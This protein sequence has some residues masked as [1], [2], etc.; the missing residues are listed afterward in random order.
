MKMIID[1]E[2]LA[3]M[4][5]IASR[6][7]SRLPRF[8]GFVIDAKKG[9]VRIRSHNGEMSIDTET[10][11]V[12]VTRPGSV[13]APREL[14]A[15][16]SRETSST[17]VME[18]G[19]ES[20]G[21]VGDRSTFKLRLVGTPDDLPPSIVPK[22]GG[23]PIKVVPADLSRAMAAALHAA[24][25][26]SK[27]SMDGVCIDVDNRRLLCVAT[28][29]ASL[30]AAV[31]CNGSPKLT[32]PVLVPQNACAAI[33]DFDGDEARIEANKESVRFIGEIEGVSV[34]IGSVLID[35]AFV[36]WRDLLAEDRPNRFSV[37]REAMERALSLATVIDNC[38]YQNRVVVTVTGKSVKFSGGAVERG[39]AEAE[40]EAEAEA[41]FRFGAKLRFLKDALGVFK[42]SETLVFNYAAPN[43]TIVLKNHQATFIFVPMDVEK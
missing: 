34:S 27:Y 10:D 26:R 6:N 21:I 20:L 1:R 4:L 25:D 39:S 22:Q 8:Q 11:C 18:A 14:A 43:K 13:F 7:P 35:G 19:A 37:Q 2:K 12:D 16:A 42:D 24:G 40:V 23:E 38:E 36:P 41:D 15:V 9:S 31:V 17:L 29:G 28:N 32:G 3:S 33:K 5:E 30:C